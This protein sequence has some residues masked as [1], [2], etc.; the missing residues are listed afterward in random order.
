[1]KV[2][3]KAAT[4]IILVTNGTE[5]C[6]FLA[7]SNSRTFTTLNWINVLSG[8]N[9]CIKLL[10]TAFS[11]PCKARWFWTGTKD[12]LLTF[13]LH[14]LFGDVLNHFDLI[15]LQLLDIVIL[16]AL[17]V[18]EISPAKL[19]VANLALDHNF[20]TIS[21]DVISQLGSSHL[22]IL[23]EVA[24][25]ATILGTLIVISMTLKLTDSFPHDLGVLITLVRE[26]TEIDAVSNNW[27]NFGQE[28]A[29]AFTVG[30]RH[31][32][33]AWNST[34]ITH[35]CSSVSG[36]PSHGL[37]FPGIWRS[38]EL[39]TGFFHHGLDSSFVLH[40]LW[41]LLELDLAV[42]TEDFVALSAFKW[43][44]W[45]KSAHNTSYF[46]SQFSLKLVLDLII[47][48]V[49]RGNWIWSHNF[50]N[51]SIWQH[52]V[53]SHLH[54]KTHFICTHFLSEI[55]GIN[56]VRSWTSHWAPIRLSNSHL[57]GSVSRTV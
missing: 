15:L 24:D 17:V 14:H 13:E 54:I 4:T 3:A 19:F 44:I 23:W 33:A 32:L 7:L 47:F 51:S 35:L 18:R 41:V 25:V 6:F 53:V 55:L 56:S 49:N 28:I 21:F 10:S 48:N 26:L 45:E 1:L 39:L 34:I 52:Q 16:E 31:G 12:L 20:G 5:I 36:Q 46:F 50:I 30:A 2:I 11:I 42:L 37:S 38:L 43:H 29:L 27:V 57:W 22:L 40:K 8:L 9:H